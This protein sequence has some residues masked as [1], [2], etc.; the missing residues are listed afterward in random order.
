MSDV[1]GTPDQAP[2]PQGETAEVSEF[3]VLLDK[4]FRAKTDQAKSTINAAVE[5]LA[6]KVLKGATVISD[7]ALAT[8]NQLIA[9]LD[10]LLT[11]QVNEILHHEDFQKLEGAWR[12]LSHLVSRTE[13]DTMLKI[14]VMNVS[15]ADLAKELKRFEGVAWDQS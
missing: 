2:T 1:Q 5:T 14:R 3:K 4:S 13:T 8:I 9:G 10:K 15:K 7:D 12:G 6:E 11:D